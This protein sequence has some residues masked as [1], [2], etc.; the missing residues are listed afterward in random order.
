MRDQARIAAALKKLAEAV[1]DPDNDY[2][3]QEDLPELPSASD[4]DSVT[5]IFLRGSDPPLDDEG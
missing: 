5:A 4:S 1:A 2:R 3:W